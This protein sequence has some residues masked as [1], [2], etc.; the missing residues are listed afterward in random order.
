[1][2]WDRHEERETE[3][4][5]IYG[6]GGEE[7]EMGAVRRMIDSRVWALAGIRLF[8]QCLCFSGEGRGGS[9]TGERINVA[10]K[11][12]GLHGEAKKNS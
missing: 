8:I 4:I 5:D 9:Q 2:V 10:A 12:I 7:I 11:P 3:E 6:A 1:M